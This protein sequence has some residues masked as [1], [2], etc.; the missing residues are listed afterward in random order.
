VEKAWPRSPKQLTAE[1]GPRV[2]PTIL[3]SLQLSIHSPWRFK[4]LKFR[5]HPKV[6]SEK[7]Q[8]EEMINI[9]ASLLIAYSRR[10]IVF[11]Y[12]DLNLE[13]CPS[14]GHLLSGCFIRNGN[15]SAV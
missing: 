7:Q 9:R 8:P 14:A 13:I 4:T 5:T 2:T 15:Q 12:S 10:Q 11:S 1:A 6:M 3:L